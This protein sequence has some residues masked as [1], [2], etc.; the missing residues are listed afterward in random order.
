MSGFS[1]AVYLS[2]YPNAQ[3]EGRMGFYDLTKV[4]DDILLHELLRHDHHDAERTSLQRRPARA[5]HHVGTKTGK[6]Q[7]HRSSPF[8]TVPDNGCA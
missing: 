1:R 7:R 4:G 2:L 3:V 6:L 8:L 5:A